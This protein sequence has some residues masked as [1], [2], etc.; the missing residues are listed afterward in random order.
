LCFATTYLSETHQKYC[1]SQKSEIRWNGRGRERKKKKRGKEAMEGETKGFLGGLSLQNETLVSSAVSPISPGNRVKSSQRLRYEAEV[2]LIRRK[3]GNLE[4]IRDSLGLSQRK[5]AQL[6]LVD[7]SA[8]TRWTKGTES[9]PPH[10]Y[11]ALQ[12]YLALQDKYP[13]LD[14][15]FWLSTVARV[16]ESSQT[17][18][19]E[20]K[21]DQK[22]ES[23]GADFSTL[24]AEIARLKSELKAQ[25]HQF[26]AA[27]EVIELRERRLRRQFWGLLIVVG[28]A[29]ALVL[30]RM[31]SR[32]FIGSF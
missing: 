4:T 25:T 5:M 17:R 3:L 31:V 24:T 26:T 23:L 10:I 32:L 19:Q 18:A 14:V 2:G 27:V 29:I 28:L 15:G 8:W 6:L 21:R 20:Q 22:I 16:D 11:R 12:W 9:A 7:P 1:I 30:G 13:A